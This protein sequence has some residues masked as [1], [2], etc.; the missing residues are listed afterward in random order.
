MHGAATWHLDER[1]GQRVCRPLA[2][3]VHEALEIGVEVL[4]H[5]VEHWLVIFLDVLHTQQPGGVGA[6]TGHYSVLART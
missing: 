2:I 1:L 4:K 3:A 6:R 5:Q